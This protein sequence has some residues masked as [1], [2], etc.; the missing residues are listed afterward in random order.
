[1]RSISIT[2]TFIL[3]GAN[4]VAQEWEPVTGADRLREVFSDTVLESKL[5]D[6]VTVT[7][8]YKS[9][10][11][12]EVT[13]QGQKYPR[14]WKVQGDDLICIKIDDLF[15]CFR[16]ERNLEKENEF[17]GSNLAT[18]AV[19]EF[20]VADRVATVATGQ[21]ATSGKG[22]AAAPSN[23]EL[24]A[25][26]SNPTTPVMTI[27]NNFDYVVF[28]GDL[29]EADDQSA[30]RYTFQTVFPY[31]LSGGGSV[32]FRPGIPVL[33]NDPVPNGQGGFDSKGVDLGDTG[34]DFS[35]GTT[36]TS[37]LIWGGGLV[38]T[39]PTATDDALG[40]D[41]WSL[42]PE[43]LL[44]V[45]RKWGVL[46]G[47]LSHQWD[48]AG[49]DPGV[50]TN[51]TTLNYIYAFNLSDGW[52]IFSAPVITYDHT[53]PNDKLTVPLGIGLSKTS[54]IK[55]RA[56]KFQVQYWNYVEGS[57]LFAPKH[58]IRIAINPVIEAPWNRGK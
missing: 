57:D 9:D 6:G 3:L 52:Q 22:G 15:Q 35:Y 2:V 30:F 47:I 40:K 46:T 25:K 33:F 8:R 51:L 7:G 23:A 17:R 27:G 55:G 14:E 21:A 19:I 43:L 36:T 42:G 12:G 58:L 39:I 18:G 16:L 49:G 34:F 32:F 41:Q 28:D 38:G 29:P 56:W 54:M 53:R 50:E 31:K 24:A 11:T 37:G 48:V 26:L 13:Y 20:T 10:G 5:R 45:I 44:G 1:M 4:A